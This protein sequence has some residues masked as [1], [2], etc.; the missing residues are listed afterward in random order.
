MTNE[1]AV[2]RLKKRICCEKPVQH[3]C[4]DDCMHGIEE[5]EIAMAIEALEKQIPKKL[6]TQTGQCKCG[7]FLPLNFR[8]KY[9]Q[10]CGQM[11]DWGK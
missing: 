4:R 1:E 11:I 9:C 2:E 8:I 3:F 7:H 5:C 10:N 6:D